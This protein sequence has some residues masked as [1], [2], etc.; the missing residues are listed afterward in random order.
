MPSTKSLYIK[1]HNL[2]LSFVGTSFINSSTLKVSTYILL[3]SYL[4]SSSSM[5]YFN[6]I[7]CNDFIFAYN[8][9]LLSYLLL[10]KLVKL[11]TE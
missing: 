6:L 9:V 3:I 5:L 1:S 4:N 8:Y 11:P 10:N 7:N 2:I